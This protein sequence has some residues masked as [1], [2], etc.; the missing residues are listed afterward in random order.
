SAAEGVE[1]SERP[2]R[3]NSD[4]ARF[5]SRRIVMARKDEEK[6]KRRKHRLEKKHKRQE[7]HAVL[8]K[9]RDVLDQYAA[10]GDPASF[11]G[12]CDETLARPDLVKADLMLFATD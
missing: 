1:R 2:H 9:V 12:T 11:P 4:V 6:K 8:A 10:V 5:D 7:A 3:A